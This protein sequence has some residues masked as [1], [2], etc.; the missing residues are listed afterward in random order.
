[1]AGAGILLSIVFL[2]FYFLCI[3]GH[4]SFPIANGRYGAYWTFYIFPLKTS[5]EI[6][7]VYIIIIIVKNLHSVLLT[8]AFIVLGFFKSIYG[9]S[10]ISTLIQF[11][12][13]M[14]CYPF[15]ILLYWISIFYFE[16][17]CKCKCFY[18]YKISFAFHRFN[19][20]CAHCHT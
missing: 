13:T 5:I 17:N 3:C 1:M 15:S 12:V 16:N 8:Y 10:F 7:Y 2:S 11:Y 19:I 6:N 18:F 4:F 14:I 9:F 20:K